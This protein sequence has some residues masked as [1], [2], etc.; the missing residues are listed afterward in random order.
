MISLKGNLLSK[1]NGIAAR[2]QTAQGRRRF[3]YSPIIVAL[4]FVASFTYG[5]FSYSRSSV[6]T[7]EEW[8]TIPLLSQVRQL[9]HSPD[10]KL[11]GEKEDRVNI[12]LLGMGG[13]GHEGPYLTDTI[14]VASIRPSDNHVAL[15]SIPRDLLVPVPDHGWRKINSA[16]AFGELTEHGRGGDYA[17]KLVANLLGVDIPYY[18]RIDFSAFTNIIDSVG[19]IDVYVDT[20]FTDRTYP[21][22]D[23]L[24]QTISFEEGWQHMDGDTALKYARSRHGSAGEG[25]DFARATRQQKVLAALKK[26]FLSLR[27]YRNPSVIT[28][29]L[30]SLQAH[31]TTNINIG[32]ML[33]LVKMAQSIDA[34]LDVSHLVLDDSTSSPLTAR[35]VNGAYVLV[36]KNNDWE[37]L[38]TVAADVFALATEEELP[39]DTEVPPMP[40]AIEDPGRIEIRNGTGRSGLARTTAGELA[41]L[42]L[43][44]VK[45]GNAD[46]FSYTQTTIYDLT[47]GKK[48]GSLA[49][50]KRAIP[51]AEI[52]D[53]LPKYLQD[54]AASGS[55][56][57]LVILGAAE[58]DRT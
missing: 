37:V 44:V 29:T 3:F 22:E 32:E 58:D 4:L 38:R 12:L 39:E 23:Y 17:R 26:K 43:R 56:D 8:K 55:T 46:S 42:G 24:T 33:R 40:L 16:N 35:I 25:S 28:N 52:D 10:R 27:T 1:K 31:V 41:E 14:M 45:I 48:P 53:T 34:E 50:L 57:F 47:G 15:L 11:I 9:I 36:P 5:R 21:T 54:A 30:A 18:V 51:D 49:K 20:S 2:P 13:E 6:M 19:G 7:F